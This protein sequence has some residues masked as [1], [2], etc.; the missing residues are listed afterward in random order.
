[1]YVAR[2]LTDMDV[3]EVSWSRCWTERCEL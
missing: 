1:M 3:I 2:D